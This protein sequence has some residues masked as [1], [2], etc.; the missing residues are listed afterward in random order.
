MIETE[1]LENLFLLTKSVQPGIIY[2][3]MWLFSNIIENEEL[4]H[5]I[6]KIIPDFLNRIN[7]LLS[8]YSN[9]FHFNDIFYILSWL[10]YRI[11]IHTGDCYLENFY[12]TI[13]Y[14]LK[15]LENEVN[16]FI[17]KIDIDIV[18]MNTETENDLIDTILLIF[19]KFTRYIED[20][21]ILRKLINS[22]LMTSITKLLSI[23][24]DKMNSDDLF[25]IFRVVGGLLS[26]NN[27][28][29]VDYLLNNFC[30]LEKVE[31][32]LKNFAYI[33]NP[34]ISN[35]KKVL[36]EMAWSLSNITGGSKSQI[37]K[38]LKTHIPNYILNFTKKIKDSNY[39]K[40]VLF[41]FYNAFD[42][43]SNE[44]KNIVLSDDVLNLITE[45]ISNTNY[46]NDVVKIALDFLRLIISEVKELFDVSV[47][48][49]IKRKLEVNNIPNV[50]DRL[51]YSSSQ[52][53]AEV[54]ELILLDNWSINDY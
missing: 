46:N 28:S 31:E 15:V 21:E 36:K 30:F 47:Y 32:I 48:K 4:C 7:T 13:P 8:N 27:D 24:F 35:P 37:E 45:A 2:H 53:I 11:F 19:D 34:K 41:M 29:D 14:F 54:A 44:S 39:Y 38:V 51:Q 6:I 40:E 3:T 49:N 33:T 1:T 23:P 17:I 16:N 20:S 18:N 5:I 43:G 50:L 26:S 42:Y 25:L 52:E 9:T 22:S 12:Q 10:I